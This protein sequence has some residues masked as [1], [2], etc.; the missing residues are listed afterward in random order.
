MKKHISII[1]YGL[2]V[3][4]LLV[5][6]PSWWQRARASK[7]GVSIANTLK[8]ANKYRKCLLQGKDCSRKKKI[9]L[10]VA[11]IAVLMGL[12]LFVE[13]WRK[14][15]IQESVVRPE[16]PFEKSVKERQA[17]EVGDVGAPSVSLGKEE[18]E[19]VP[20]SGPSLWDLIDKAPGD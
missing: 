7:A 9:R 17:E 6:Q 1:T 4:Q 15:Q 18:E 2:L 20:V 11:A 13:G 19:E 10:R 16:S 8:E 14:R 5:A 3:S 12:L